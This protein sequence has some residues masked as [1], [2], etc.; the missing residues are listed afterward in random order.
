MIKL[1]PLLLILIFC[2]N[3]N[4]QVKPIKKDFDLEKTFNPQLTDT[5][6]KII[7][8]NIR[9]Y[10]EQIREDPSNP[11]LYLNRGVMYANLGLFPDAITDYNKAIGLKDNFAEAFYNRG[12]ARARF[13]FNER[14]CDDVKKAADLGLQ[15][16]KDLFKQH[17]G[18][19]VPEIG[20]IKK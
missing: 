9:Q 7:K 10:S 15:D 19:F 6:R 20:D 5:E 14:A 13:M 1:I 18:R 17:C 11:Y 8:E 16:A 12:I 2:G 4:A 3:L